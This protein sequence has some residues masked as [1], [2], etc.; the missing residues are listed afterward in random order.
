MAGLYEQSCNDFAN[1]SNHWEEHCQ[2]EA[3][4]D[5]YNREAFAGSGESD[6][7]LDYEAF[8]DYMMGDDFVGPREQYFHDRWVADYA[9]YY[10]F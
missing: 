5:D 9:P 1:Y 4:L 8:E 3:T 2:D 7:Q 10:K 6:A